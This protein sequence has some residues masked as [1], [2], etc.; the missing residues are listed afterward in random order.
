MLEV[1]GL[2]AGYGAAEVLHGVDLRVG[3]GEIVTL[4]G[5]NGAGKSTLLKC[6]SGLLTPTSGTALL[7]GLPLLGRTPAAIVR[8][9]VA[10]VPEGR[11]VF[12]GLTVA[13]NLR[14]GA[15]T[16]LGNLSAEEIASRIGEVCRLFPAL[17]PRLRAEAGGLSGGQQQMLAIARGLMSRPRLLL[18]DEPSLGLAPLVVAE[19]FSVLKELRRTG[20]AVLLVEQNARQALAVSDHGYVIET[21]SVALSGTGEELLGSPDVADRYLG[22]GPARFAAAADAWVLSVGE[23]LRR[24]MAHNGAGGGRIAARDRSPARRRRAAEQPPRP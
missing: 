24:V 19:I 5:A 6:L 1:A 22:V 21:G 12:A 13:D 18:L 3:R 20:V 2:H 9:G 15:Y 14:L 16:Q 8:M 17:S 4:V 11:Q 23:R 10:H 7:D